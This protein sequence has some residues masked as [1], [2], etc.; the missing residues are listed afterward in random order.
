MTLHVLVAM[1]RSPMAERALEHALTV[2]P[3]AEV[4][5]LYV[6]DYIEESYS[7]RALVGS[8]ELHERARGH[9]E[10]R[11]ETA[12]EMADEHGTEVETRTTVGDPAREIV[13]YARDHDVDVV[14]VGSH[15]R[16]TLSRI[17]LGSVAESV[18]RRAPV[19]V[20][21]VR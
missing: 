21:V 8:E 18:V 3:E 4:T 14:V 13:D 12:R 9:A 15:G 2:Y 10:E 6:I 7:A 5:V 11:F 16:D 19:P 1:D 17:L 20:T